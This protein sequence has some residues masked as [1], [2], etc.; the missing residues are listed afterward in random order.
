[1]N[2]PTSRLQGESGFSLGRTT[3]I[4]RDE[5][6]FQKFIEK[7]RKRFSHIITETLKTQLILKGVCNDVEWEEIKEDI[8]L[9]FQSDNAFAEQ[10][11]LDVLLSRMAI[12]PQVDPYL[13]KYFS[14][15]WVQKNILRM[16]DAQITGMDEQINNEKDDP[17]AQPTFAGGMGGDPSMMGG[18]L[19]P[20]MMGSMPGQNP[21]GMQ[22]GQEQGMDHEQEEQPYQP[23][24]Y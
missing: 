6:K 18:G 11:E 20:S 2:I 21:N 12:M 9:V 24:R 15:E 1:L 22:P 10:K 23:P 17:T 3:E 13:G 8:R 7:L 16:T 4:S 5:V 14:K 19:D